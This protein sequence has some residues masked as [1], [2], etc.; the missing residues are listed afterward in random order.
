M[1]KN[2]LLIA[3]AGSGKTTF[4]IEKAKK[5]KDEN[6][7]ITTYTEANKAEITM[8]FNG[9]IPK[10]ITIQTWFSF[11][12]QHGVRPYQSEMNNDLQKKKIGFYLTE[13]AS[14]TYKG[15]NGRTYSYGETKN[16][17]KCYFTKSLK[18]YSDKISKFIV[19]CNQK[20]N[21]EITNR[22][23]RI[24]PHI[25][26]DEIQDLAGWELEI[27][28]LFLN[29]NSN[30]LLVGDPRQVTYLTHHSSKYKKYKNGK[31]KEF[32]ENE[33]NKKEKVCDI[34]ETTL[35]K[36]HRNNQEICEFS[37]KLFPEYPSCDPCTCEK[38]RNYTMP[39]EGVFL[40]K[41]EGVN[42]YCKKYYPIIL[43]EKL[44]IHPEWNYGKSKGLTFDRVLIY[45]TKPIVNWIKDQ[46]SKLAPTSRCKFYVALTRARYSVGI[47]CDYNDN[48]NYID[49]LE[50]YK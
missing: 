18:I 45:P 27:L 10:N 21:G 23:A 32:I 39:Q 6:V 5:I 38:C 15:T 49:G 31:I 43:R 40:V 4:L 37:S 44:A 50:K 25:Y 16:F 11:L 46:N 3:V 24:Y 7:L 1:S 13:G 30:I 9:N 33:C 14:G 28:K 29:S 17:Y 26:I 19:K 42:E 41:E 47:V 8:K 12:L 36:F 2:K 34:D 35:Q 20:T 22:I 48:T